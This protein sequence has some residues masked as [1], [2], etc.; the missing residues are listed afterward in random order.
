M[1]PL[2]FASLHQQ[3]MSEEEKDGMR[4]NFRKAGLLAIVA[5]LGATLA[6]AAAAKDQTI[7]GEVGDALCGRE[8]SMP[9]TAIDCIRE[10]IGKGGRYS[11]LVGDK[12]YVLETEDK[13]LLDA[14]ERESGK[15]VKIT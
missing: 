2:L 14:L 11:L 6:S 12:V 4:T 13:T 5:I 10:C 7:T 3:E 9:G 8:H 15:R 1:R